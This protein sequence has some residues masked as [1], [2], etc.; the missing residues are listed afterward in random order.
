MFVESYSISETRYNQ[1]RMINSSDEIIGDRHDIVRVCKKVMNKAA[2]KRLISKQEACVLLGELDL[3]YCTETIS[4]VS[5]SNSQRLTVSSDSKGKKTLIKQY[6]NRPEALSHYS[7]YDFYHYMEN[8]GDKTK[9]SAKIPHFI[10]INGTP[11]YPVTID[12]AKHVLIVHKPWRSYPESNDWIGDFNRFINDPEAPISAKMAYQRVHCRWL[13]K[14]QGYDPVSEI[15]DH[16]TNP[17]SCSDLQLM[18][19]IGLHQSDDDQYDDSIIRNLEIGKKH[20]WDKNPKVI[21]IPDKITSIE[22]LSIL[23][24]YI[25]ADNNLTNEFLS[26]FRFGI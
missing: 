22:I 9:R 2:A 10:G 21:M 11:T 15:Y 18:Q 6:I 13:S 8:G 12:Y 25:I 23:F 5:I 4:S 17:I 19:L 7:L 26:N 16:S 20:K 3:C 14:T 1:L 24:P